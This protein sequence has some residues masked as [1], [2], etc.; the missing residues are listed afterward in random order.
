MKKLMLD[1][2]SLSVETFEVADVSE[3]E[4][5]TVKGAQMATL[6]LSGCI[7]ACMPSGPKPCLNPGPC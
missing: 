1:V 4:G 6:M 7:S 5:G 3:S 2:E